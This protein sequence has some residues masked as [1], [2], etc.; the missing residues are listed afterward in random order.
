M[1]KGKFR[2]IG[3][4]TVIPDGPNGSWE[5]QLQPVETDIGFEIEWGA[6]GLSPTLDKW[7]KYWRN[8]KL[9][10]RQKACSTAVE[11]RKVIKAFVAKVVELEESVRNDAK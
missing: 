4:P 10:T 8:Y 1:A 2:R 5:F 6:V 3:K 7:R 11:A 9:R